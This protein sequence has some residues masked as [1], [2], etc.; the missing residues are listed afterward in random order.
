MYIYKKIISLTFTGKTLINIK[1]DIIVIKKNNANN[2]N[3]KIT[4]TDINTKISVSI[5]RKITSNNVSVL[6]KLMTF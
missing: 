2:L 6:V 1:Q 4:R 3:I 5:D